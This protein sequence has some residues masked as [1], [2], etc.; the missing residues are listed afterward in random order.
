MM[1]ICTNFDI[2]GDTTS[3]VILKQLNSQLKK[4]HEN[5]C[6]HIFSRIITVTYILVLEVKFYLIF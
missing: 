1:R 6:S 3:D 5:K 2:E 4:M